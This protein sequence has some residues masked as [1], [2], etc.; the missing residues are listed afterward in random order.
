MRTATIKFMCY[1]EF[2]VTC[3]DGFL[4]TASAKGGDPSSDVQ[5]RF[6]LSHNPHSEVC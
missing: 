4:P 6:Q 3:G 5:W 1:D 2:P